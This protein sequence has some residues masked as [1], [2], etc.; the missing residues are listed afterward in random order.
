M[1]WN[2]YRIK[3]RSQAVDMISYTLSEKGI[4]GIE[5]EDRIPITEEEKKAM[6]IDM[7]PD[8]GEDDGTA[9]V[10]FYVEP[11]TDT[12]ERIADIQAALEQLRSFMDPGELSMERTQ[13]ADEDWINKWKQFW[14]P[15]WADEHILICPS[16]EETGEVPDGTIV[17]S[18]DPGTAF[19]TGAHHTT[20]MCIHQ[21]VKYLQKGDTV[22][23]IGCGSGILSIVSKKLGAGRVLAV[24]IDPDA[25][26][27]SEE[28]AVRNDTVFEVRQGDILGDED[29]AKSCGTADFDIVAA[30]IFST[31]IIPLAEVLEKEM[32]PGALF[33]CSG[34]MNTKEQ[35]VKDALTGHGFEILETLYSE[36][37]VSITARRSRVL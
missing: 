2:K 22:F 1:K 10:S 32:K 35:A 26:S 23:D 5:V 33:I 30:N 9:Y 25:V 34:I 3:T 14:K 7:L 6:F 36:E 18:L 4:E 13:T 31:I 17:I 11:E 21:L 15:F 20:K 12:P 16:W 28:N 37:W 8:L 27:A 19:G 24:D 29:F